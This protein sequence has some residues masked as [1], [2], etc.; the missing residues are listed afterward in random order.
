MANN[1]T[2]PEREEAMVAMA[3]AAVA[4]QHEYIHGDDQK[5]VATESGQVPTIAKQAR[6]GAEKVTAVL[7][8]AAVQG[9]GALP[10]PSIEIGLVHTPDDGLFSVLSADDREL[11][12]LYQRVDGAAVERKR[13][14]SAKRVDDVED[15]TLFAV[16]AAVARSLDED[17]P[18]AITD[19]LMGLI[20]GIHKAGVVHAIL[21]RLPGLSHFGDY[22]WVVH[23]ANDTVLL[24]FKWSGEVVVYPSVEAAVP[25]GFAWNEGSV[26]Q[27]DIFTLIGGVPYQ[28]TSSGDNTS[29]QVIAGQVHYVERNGTVRSRAVPLPVAGSTAPFVGKIIHIIFL[30]Q[31]LACGIG[32]GAPVTTQPSAANR[33]FTLKAGVQLVD[34]A[35]V[36]TS[37]MVAPFTPLMANVAKEPPCLQV[38]AALN[39][40]RSLPA[41]AGLLISNHARG[42]QGI[43]TLNKGT[44]PYQNSLTAITAAK[45]ECDAKGL[46][47]SVPC[48]CWNQGQHDGGMAAGV[49][50]DLLVQLQKDYEADI[51]AILGKPVRVPMIITQMS[52]WTAPVY[53]RAFSNIPHEQFQVSLDFPDRFVVAGPQYWLPSNNDGIHLPAKS[54]ARDGTALS[55]A[56]DAVI[57]GKKWQPTACFSAVREGTTVTLRFHVPHGPLVID[58]LNVTDP[59]NLGIR[60]ID[61]TSS[62]S[63]IGVELEGYDTLRVTLSGEPTGVAPMIGIADIGVAGN[64]AGPDTGPRTC[65]RDNS[66]SLDA[67]GVPVY[68]WACHQ[69]IA[70]TS[71]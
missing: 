38:G 46:P 40:N 33:V 19:A 71:V 26:G 3:E 7:E 25:T 42:A 14:Y 56:I 6:L 44:I 32:S 4:I 54:Y 37:D 59:G 45:A 34:E 58:T 18:I 55:G 23:D 22:A 64:R 53:N 9:A 63:V 1:E 61:S 67:F 29:P 50:Y 27:R 57:E 60:W 39:R 11:T 62:V 13:S 31:S 30:G 36:L 15:S 24:G 52:N 12:I 2:I 17:Y 35:G 47:Y 66:P 49:Y 65:I 28:L 70:V 69:R 51:Q 48:I 20:F 16:E 21:D 41:D 5:D 43:R 10:Y 8:E 68:N